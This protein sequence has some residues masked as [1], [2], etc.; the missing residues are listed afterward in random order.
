MAYQ[1]KYSGKEIEE[2]LDQI[3]EKVNKEQVRD[4]VLSILEEP[5]AP[6]DG[7]KYVRINGE[8]VENNG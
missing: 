8:W 4:I 6:K 3:P 7:K 2:R 5:D 1:I